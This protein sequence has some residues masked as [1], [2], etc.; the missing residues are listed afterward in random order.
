M[1]IN[2]F[3]PNCCGQELSP[4]I[5]GHFIPAAVLQKF[6]MIMDVISARSNYYCSIATCSYPLRPKDIERNLGTCPVCEKQTC[7]ECKSLAHEGECKK[8]EE[9]EKLLQL[10]AENKWQ[11]CPTCGQMVTRT[12]GCNMMVVEGM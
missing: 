5:F 12:G 11:V 3:P 1:N 4:A 7:L 8:D 6:N 9:E 2:L 10:A